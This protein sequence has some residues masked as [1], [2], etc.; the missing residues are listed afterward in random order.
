VP[1]A[2]HELEV[3]GGRIVHITSFLDL[4][5]GLFRLL[6]LPAAID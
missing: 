4:D 2:L 1:W 6:G 3:E 5:T